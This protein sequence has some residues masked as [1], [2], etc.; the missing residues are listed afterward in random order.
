MA[1]PADVPIPDSPESPYPIKTGVCEIVCG[2]GRGSAELGIPTAN[3]PFEELPESVGGLPLGVFFGFARLQKSAPKEARNMQRQD[4]T[5]VHFNYGQR[6][7]DNDLRVLP[8]VLSMGLNPFYHNKAKTVEIHVMHKFDHDFYG[9]Q[10]TFT[11][12]GY[13]RPELDYTTKEAL[14]EDIQTDIQ[15][16]EKA[17]SSP[18]YAKYQNL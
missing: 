4:G 10:I 13:I 11:I 12:L 6:L 7:T 1:R 15:I 17:L 3:V 2:F 9:A 14:I 18:E 16:A 5:R 8:V